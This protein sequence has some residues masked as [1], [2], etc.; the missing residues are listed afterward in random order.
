MALSSKAKVILVFLL[1]CCVSQ[2]ICISEYD[3]GPIGRAPEDSG[4]EDEEENDEEEWEDGNKCCC[5]DQDEPDRVNNGA[6]NY[7]EDVGDG[8]GPVKVEASPKQIAAEADG[9]LLCLDELVVE[10]ATPRKCADAS[11]NCSLGF[12]MCDGSDGQKWASSNGSIRNRRNKCIK[13]VADG[14]PLK[15]GSCEAD[16]EGEV[17]RWTTE[18]VRI[19]WSRKQNECLSVWKAAAKS[20]ELVLRPCNGTDK[21]Q[22]FKF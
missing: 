4:E 13:Y 11:R 14:Q 2:A 21:S 5:D 1:A 20:Y 22:A 12:W 3:V 6:R 17:N 15:S 9:D 10:R 19:R 8:D 16:E 7:L 18:G